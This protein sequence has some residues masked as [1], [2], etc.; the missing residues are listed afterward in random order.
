MK[1]RT[2]LF[3]FFW[4]LLTILSA[5]QFP[6]LLDFI[7]G[8]LGISWTVGSIL[9]RLSVLVFLTIS[10]HFFFQLLIPNRS[11][12]WVW[13]FLIALLPGIALSFIHP[14]FD[15]DYGSYDDAMIFKGIDELEGDL[16]NTYTFEETPQVLAFFTTDC[17]HC[18]AVAKKLGTNLAAG[19]SLPVHAFFSGS[20]EDASIFLQENNGLNITPHFIEPD[21]VYLTYSGYIFP[22]IFLLD[23]DGST[24]LH[25]E[26]D[27]VNYTALDFLRTY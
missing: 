1:L 7:V 18:K 22:S 5:T 12:K 13:K 24:L 15:I 3:G 9:S 16:V 27:V 8:Q 11:F 14:I 2:A 10:I 20:E 26:G 17:N 6:L 19:Q 23:A 21:S 25:W 4:L